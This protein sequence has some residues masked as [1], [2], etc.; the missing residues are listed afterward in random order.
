MTPARDFES[1][2]RHAQLPPRSG[3]RF[4]CPRIV[5]TAQGEVVHT[6]D[7]REL[8]MRR[9]EPGDV[10]ALQRCF[11][12][13]SPQ[14]V[15]RRFMHAMSELPISM[16]QRLCRIDPELEAAYALMDETVKPAELR[17]VGRIFVDVAANSAEFS[18]LV[19]REWTRIGLGALVMQRLVDECR[20]R[21]LSELWGYVLMENRP[22]LDLCKELGFVA[23]MVPGE[24]GTAQISLKL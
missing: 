14:D 6:A 9:V 5:T 4:A 18:V 8:V 23:K 22:M 1:H 15:R 16:A 21:G 13:L 7:G 11:K 19:E 24:T 17:G 10:A 3:E 2:S 20:R 12:R